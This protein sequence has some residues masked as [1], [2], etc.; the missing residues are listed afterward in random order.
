MQ[1]K[2]FAATAT[3]QPLTDAGQYNIATLVLQ[4][5]GTWT[6]SVAIKGRVTPGSSVRDTTVL[7]VADD[8]ALG[9][10]TPASATPSTT[11]PT[12]NGLYW[13]R[14]DGLAVDVDVTVATGTG[15]IL[16]YEVING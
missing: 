13:Y 9:Y 2:S 10:T 16:T 15:P 14:I 3:N 8:V 6:G 5:T 7:A 1:Q 4:I 11:S 12:V